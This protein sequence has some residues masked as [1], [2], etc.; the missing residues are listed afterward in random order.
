MVKDHYSKL[1]FEPEASGHWVLDVAN[2]AGHPVQIALDDAK[3]VAS[4]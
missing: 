4:A 2:Y 3:E 1:G